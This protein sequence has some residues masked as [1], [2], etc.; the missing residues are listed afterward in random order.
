MIIYIL[1][2]SRALMVGEFTQ[3]GVADAGFI[4]SSVI[5]VLDAAQKYWPKF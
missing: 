2:A 1:S 3:D 5:P 4:K